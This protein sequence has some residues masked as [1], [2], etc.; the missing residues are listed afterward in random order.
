MQPGRCS[1]YVALL[2]PGEKQ[3]LYVGVNAAQRELVAWQPNC[4]PGYGSSIDSGAGDPDDRR[5]AVATRFAAV[6]VHISN[7]ARRAL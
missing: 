1:A 5:E 6:H 3:G 7:P 2:T 4:G